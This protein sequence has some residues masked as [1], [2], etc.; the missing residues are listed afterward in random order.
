[1][2]FHPVKREEGHIVKTH[3]EGHGVAI[4]RNDF[5]VEVLVRLNGILKQSV[6]HWDSVSMS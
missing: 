2:I 3:P 5:D 4:P 6:E 1:M